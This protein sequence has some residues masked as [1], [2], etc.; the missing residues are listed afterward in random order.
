MSLGQG[1]RHFSSF[2]LRVNSF[3]I[4]LPSLHHAIN[5]SLF[6]D[7]LRKFLSGH[8]QTTPV[9]WWDK[10]GSRWVSIRVRIARHPV[11]ADK[12]NPVDGLSRGRYDGPWSEVVPLA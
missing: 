8:N 9:T 11:V 5:M 1:M 10:L 3:V 12:F 7:G 4:C 2:W 6:G